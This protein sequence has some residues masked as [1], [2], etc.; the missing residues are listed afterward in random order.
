MFG[1]Y[2]FP[3]KTFEIDGLPLDNGISEVR[4]ARKHGGIV[5]AGFLRARS[6]KVKGI[7]HNATE[8]SSLTELNSLQSNL[9]AGEDEFKHRSDRYI[10]CR[11]RRILPKNVKGS[12]KALINISIDF[13]AEDPFFYSDGASYSDVNDVALG[14][15]SFNI[16]SG[17]NVFAEPKMFIYASGGTIT[18]GIS[19]TNLSNNNQQ[20]Q[21]HGIVAN[22]STVEFDSA[23]LEVDN[24]GADGITYFE[25]DFITL[26][27][28]SNTLQFA[29]DACRITVDHKYRWY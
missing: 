13:L 15:T 17:G 12:D 6:F 4:I 26:V 3:N 5:Q 16:N 22:G 9:L 7:I 11:T 2:E 29:G 28:G 27:A 21:W 20:M 23:L 10:N 25:G 8:A 19:L 18:D 14:T 24:D 1:D